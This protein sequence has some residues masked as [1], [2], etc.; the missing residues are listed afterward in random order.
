MP[1]PM[2]ALL[3]AATAL[4]GAL[5]G[6]AAPVIASL[7]QSRAEHRRERLRLAVELAIKQH[8]TWAETA[9]EQP[10]FEFPPLLI[11]LLSQVDI[12]ADIDSGRKVTPHRLAE[13]HSRSRA[14]HDALRELNETDPD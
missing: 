3:P 7:V 13:L 9:K 12:L 2:T 6:S 14:L 5:I 1:V 4:A 8:Q 11:T 10:T